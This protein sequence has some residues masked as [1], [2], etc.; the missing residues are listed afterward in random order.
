MDNKK[1]I[2]SSTVSI[3][4]GILLVLISTLVHIIPSY[5]SSDA[6]K[7]A[8][9]IVTVFDYVIIIAFIAL[10]IWTGMRA[11]RRYRSD[12][13]ECGVIA[14]FSHT[15]VGIVSLIINVLVGILALANILN[16]SGLK[17]NE[18]VVSGVVFGGVVGAMGI[19]VS[20]ICGIGLIVLGALL[21]FMI[22]ALGGYFGRGNSSY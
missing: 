14:A 13:M 11:A 16:A 22:G 9:T 4:I 7:V 20:V 6:A 12:S 1:I 18:A 21:N 8:S 2:A 17:S 19:G 15:I 5:I 10:Y 3:G